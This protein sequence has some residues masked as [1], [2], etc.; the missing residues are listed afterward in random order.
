ME[1]KLHLYTGDG[2][3][4]TTATYGNIVGEHNDSDNYSFVDGHVE[5][6]AKRV[7]HDWLD[8]SDAPR[9]EAQFDF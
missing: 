1:N 6:I 2:K 5:T 7:V 8:R 4:K 9:G 3:G